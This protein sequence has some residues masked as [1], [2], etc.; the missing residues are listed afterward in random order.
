MNILQYNNKKI[1]RAIF[2]ILPLGR[3]IPAQNRIPNHGKIPIDFTI[4]NPWG[5][6]ADFD[7]IPLDFGPERCPDPL[8]MFLGS[9][10]CVESISG[11]PRA[12]GALWGVKKPKSDQNPLRGANFSQSQLWN[13]PGR[14]C[15]GNETLDGF[16]VNFSVRKANYR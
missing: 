9:K 3:D 13:N 8:L 15:S 11:T 1:V 5:L 12:I 2:E 6:G 4:E 16:R 7:Q 10:F 14:H